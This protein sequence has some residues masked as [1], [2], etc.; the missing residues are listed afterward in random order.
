MLLMLV[1]YE[2]P[3]LVLWWHGVKLGPGPQELG[4]WDSGTQDPPQNLKV[5]PREPFF[6]TTKFKK[7]THI[8]V[9][10]HYFTCYTLYEKLR[11]FFKEII[12]HEFPLCPYCPL[13]K[14]MCFRLIS[15]GF[16]RKDFIIE[17]LLDIH[18][19]TL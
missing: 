4:P 15:P 13:N 2:L 8:M 9:F 18:E 3:L 16:F 12:F 6:L 7:E 5:R 1:I 10:L 11:N 14:V 19:K 17:D